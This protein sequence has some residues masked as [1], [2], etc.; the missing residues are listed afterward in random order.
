[1]REQGMYSWGNPWFRWSVV[2]LAALTVASMLVGF[3]WL[4]SVHG[5]FSAQG[6]WASICRAAG[7][8]DDLVRR[9]RAASRSVPQATNVVLERSM[10]RV[11]GQCSVGRGARWP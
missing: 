8:P 7:R 5:D 6:L 4:P 11:G 1:M 2:S 9:Q 10:A 3:V